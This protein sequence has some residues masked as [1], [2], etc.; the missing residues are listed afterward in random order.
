MKSFMHRR[1]RAILAAG[2]ILLIVSFFWAL[3]RA[4]IQVAAT[5]LTLLVFSGASLLLT[6]FIRVEVD[7]RRWGFS[8]PAILLFMVG[9]ILL[10]WYIATTATLA[11]WGTALWACALLLA[12][13][14]ATTHQQGQHRT[15]SGFSRFLTHLVMAF[16]FAG[17]LV[18]LAQI[19]GRFSDEEYYALV[20]GLVL[21]GCWLALRVL[22]EVLASHST[23]N[24]VF[25][26]RL[27]GTDGS[28]SR[29]L[30]WVHQRW[31]LL[32]VALAVCIFATV[33]IDRYQHSFYPNEAP[34]YAGISSENPFICGSVAPDPQIY[35]GSEVHKELVASL[36]TNLT[37]GV[38]ELGMLALLSGEPHWLQDFHDALMEEAIEGAF[39]GPANSVKSIQ[40]DAALRV[41]YYAEVSSIYP[42]L[43]STDEQQIIRDWLAAVNRRALTIEW[44]DWLYALAF[45]QIP[46][47]LYEN[48]E[49]GAGLLALLEAND[50]ADP[51]L[52]IRNQAYLADHLRGWMTGFRVTDDAVYYQPEWLTN[53]Y[54]QSLYTGE[55][56]GV[57]LEQ[58]F[59]WLLLQA[60]PD[61]APL[62]YNHP[63][64]VSL[65]MIA[66]L[67]AELTDDTSLLWI[68]GRAL[69]YS[70]SHDE[71][72]Q[73]QP[74]VEA[75]LQG[76]G[77][78][79][80]Q[81]SCLLYGDSGL[82]TQE[83][84]L[85]PDKI[86]FRD[87]WADE[88][89]YL[90]LNLRF[91]GW[92]RYKATN[93]IT[94]VY[95]NGP[96][97]GEQASSETI[98]WLPAGR[99]LVRDKRID[100]AALNGL[101]VSRSGMSA[102]LN[103][104]TGIGGS[105][106]QDPP[107][108]AS[109]ENFVTSEALDTSTTLISDWRGWTQRRTILFYHAG[110]IIVLD[111]AHGPDRSTAAILWQIPE[112]TQVVVNRVQL[113]GGNDPAEL[114]LVPILGTI[115]QDETTLQVKNTSNLA[116]ASVIL[117]GPWYG[118]KVSLIDGILVITQGVE[119]I[120]VPL[121]EAK[122]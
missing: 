98:G 75:M 103:S 66:L 6:G 51:A 44:V 104:L 93:T 36:E 38:P 39:S 74:G 121:D 68:A 27:K 96:L 8:W 85:A 57:Y 119:Q 64:D 31:A 45:H 107:Y 5:T 81:G 71:V 91:T 99:S 111:I 43:F 80:T 120:V 106:A 102:V 122:P 15:M 46:S 84:P 19:E 1:V 60:L 49:N 59:T 112:D 118:A 11:A 61:G 14:D 16:L 62:G 23:W 90:M 88:S 63:A 92:H 76:Q 58:S 2:L 10:I 40:Y 7:G 73:A 86:V 37:K 89:A 83:G 32:T 3:T 29:S 50:L 42:D 77:V 117:S 97:I 114:V 116:L 25:K 41:Y 17:F 48:Q 21:A 20:S 65:A 87:G 22:W 52:S 4:G 56:P 109:V 30:F 55:T 47:G 94:L 70:E 34:G 53:A 33:I 82:P 100:R 24:L 26:Q 95:Q 101:V 13:D 9:V 108:Y 35:T 69:E 18:G 28:Q 79:P 105:W 78:S 54:F 72:V 67:G 115:E 12:L 113:K 110:P